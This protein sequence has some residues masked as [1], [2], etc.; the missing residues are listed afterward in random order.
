M[1][2]ISISGRAAIVGLGATEFSK[3]SGRTELRLAMEATLAALAD[4]G[5]DPSEVEGFSS[6]TMDKVPE[7]EIA[8]LLGCKNVKFFSTVPHGGGAACAPMVHAAMAVA[9]GLAKVVVVYRAMNER[10]WYRFGTGSYGFGSTPIFE[11]V[12]YGWYMPFGF[13]TPA[14][15]VGMFARRYMHAYG[16]TSEDFGRVS[17]AVRDFAATNPAAFFHGKPITLEEH[18]ASKWIAEPLR[19][20][21]CCQH[22]SA[23]VA[24]VHAVEGAAFDERFDRRLVDG[25]GG[26]ALAEVEERGEGLGLAGRG[27]GSRGVLGLVRRG[28]CGLVALGD[29][30][31]DRLVARALDGAET[32]ADVPVR[33][34]PRFAFFKDDGEL[35]LRAVDVGRLDLDADL[36]LF[37]GL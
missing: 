1:T 23:L 11:N 21:D 32:E 36:E 25:A 4:A 22:R 14:A 26:D 9:T 37:A 5:I 10:S 24:A 2:D 18:Q 33:G 19:L 3:N 28:L 6:Y 20:L 7:Y 8:R 15:W 16:A 17:V 27:G 35:G 34:G 31:G 12:N 29:H 13:H 30:R